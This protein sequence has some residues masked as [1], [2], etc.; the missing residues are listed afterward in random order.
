MA[1]GSSVT[2][3]PRRGREGFGKLKT[4]PREINIIKHPF[5]PHHCD[6]YFYYLGRRGFWAIVSRETE[7]S[8]IISLAGVI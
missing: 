4:L 3:A 1:F 6:A 2:L 7:A 8:C 5:T